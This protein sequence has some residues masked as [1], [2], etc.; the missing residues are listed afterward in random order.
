MHHSDISAIASEYPMLH[1]YLGEL[2]FVACLQGCMVQPASWRR[3]A[4]ELPNLLSRSARST[5]EIAELAQLERAMRIAFEATESQSVS[6]SILHPSVSLLT[7]EHN[8]ASLWSAL[9]CGEPP[10]R[11]YC[12]DHPQNLVIWRHKGNSRMR[13]LGEEEYL[14]MSALH[15]G[16]NQKPATDFYVA[17]WLDSSVVRAATTCPAEK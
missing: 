3:V 12:L 4:D 9:I 1:R 8:T 2:R 14:C 15:S 11:P 10:P 5:P 17:G 13:L 6:C 7:F 16:R